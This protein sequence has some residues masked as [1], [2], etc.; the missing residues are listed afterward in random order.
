MTRRED[1][2]SDWSIVLPVKSWTSAKTRMLDL[3]FAER[4]TLVQALANDTLRTICDMPEIGTCFVVAPPEVLADLARTVGSRRFRAVE[5]HTGGEGPDPLNSAFR[6]GR[7][8]AVQEG[9]RQVALLVADLPGLTAQG[10]REFLRSVPRRSPAMVRDSAR[11][12]TTVLASRRAEWLRPEFGSGSAERHAGAGAVDVTSRCD[13]WLSHDV[14]TSRELW[15]ARV[16]PGSFLE[17]WFSRW[18]ALP[19]GSGES[20]RRVPSQFRGSSSDRH[21]YP[22]SS[23]LGG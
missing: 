4:I 8:A 23:S 6:Q 3:G 2:V 5:D 10:L 12:G 1:A 13:P 22:P 14:D 11:T 17:H 16:A 15:A 20:S 7:A 9:Y 18:S 21:A 19:V